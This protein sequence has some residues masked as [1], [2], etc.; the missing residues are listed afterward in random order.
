MNNTLV[1]KLTP[2]VCC[3]FIPSSEAIKTV[4]QMPCGDW[5]QSLEAFV[6]SDQTFS[7]LNMDHHLWLEYFC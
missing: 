3:C 7:N 6:C 4:N 2:G 1:Y 5:L